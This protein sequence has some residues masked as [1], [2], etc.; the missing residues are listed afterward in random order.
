MRMES[1]RIR[2]FAA[3]AACLSALSPLMAAGAFT[4]DDYR[5]A[6]WMT[7][8]FYGGQRSGKGVNWLLADNTYSNDYVKDSDS[9]LDLTGGWHDCGDFPMFGQTQFYSA[10]VLIRGYLAFPTGYDDLYDGTAYSGYRAKHSWNWGDGT[11]NGIPDILEEVKYAT[12][13]FIKATP[14]ASTFYY[15]KGD[16]GTGVGGEH[17]QWV[18]S[19]Y[20][21]TQYTAD[22]GGESDHSRPVWKNPNDA[23][24]PSFCA[25]AL[26]A[27]SR[28]Y[29][30]FDPAYADQCLQHARYAFQYAQGKLPNTAATANGGFYG[31]NANAG[32]DYVTAATE[33]YKAT[34][35]SSFQDQ[36]LAHAGD[37]KWHYYIF[38]YNNNDDLAFY[39][40]GV[41]LGQSAK[42]DALNQDGQFLKSY[43][44]NVNAAGVTQVGDD[45]GRMRFPAD[46]AFIAALYD[47]AKGV[48]DY[49]DFIYKQIDFIL[50]ANSAQQSFITGFCSG[51]THSPQHPHHRNV[52]LAEHPTTEIPIP[53]RNA[54]QGSLIGGALDPSAIAG[55]DTRDNYQIMEPCIDMQAGLVGALAYIVSKLAPVDTSKFHG[56]TPI[57]RLKKIKLQP[58][59]A[60]NSWGWEILESGVDVLGEKISPL[61]K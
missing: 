39:N 59:T 1:L 58:G 25:A 49:D 53:A 43:S 41:Y 57:L 46:A 33:L 5:K 52:Y 8:R 14:D 12:D 22:E 7:T 10:Y 54:E 18:T 23:S 30:K 9:G 34:G 31:A 28:A 6:L 55:E 16:G 4:V 40:L 32:D 20:Y 11:P 56:P 38:C 2:I 3:T 17:A 45:W 37:A 42:L 35:E 48:P 44:G 29:R 15:Q 13:F 36:A 47:Q 27:M 51:C 61:T 24:M 50:G 60:S 21:S 26:A 19:G